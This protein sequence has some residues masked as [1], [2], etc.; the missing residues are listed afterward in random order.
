MANIARILCPTDFSDASAH[1]VDLTTMIASRYKARIAALHVVSAAGA[2]PEFSLAARS[3][4]PRWTV[5]EQPPGRVFP[6]RD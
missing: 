5:F 1:A 2:L 3:M 6:T 4:K